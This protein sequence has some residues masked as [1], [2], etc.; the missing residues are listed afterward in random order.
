MTDAG[1]S[2]DP[3]ICIHP[4]AIIDPG[5]TL[6]PDVHVGPYSVIGPDVIIGAGCRI[7][8]HVVIKGP[9]YMGSNNRIF[10]FASVGED[11]QDKKYQG[12]P[13]RLEI[14]DD[15]VVREGVTIHRGTLQDKGVTVIGSG[16]LLM[17]YVH[18]AHD[19]VLGNHCILANNS[20]LGG[21]V[22]VGDGAV[23]GGFTGVHQFCQVGA[24]SMSAGQAAVFKDIPAFVM[25]SGNPAAPHGM[26]FEG[27]RRRGYSAEVIHTLKQ[28]YKVIYRSGQRIQDAVTHLE[29]LEPTSE[30]QLLIDSIKGSTRGIV[31]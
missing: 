7:H 31:R 12:E 9:T 27:M 22:R 13:T 20:T 1:V 11:C 15:N 26:N 30:V 24:F 29:T 28:C 14:G 19:C 5:A 21:H 4:T 6:A 3:S 2:K 16:N 17:A 18:I 10:Q 23:L 8:S 25:V